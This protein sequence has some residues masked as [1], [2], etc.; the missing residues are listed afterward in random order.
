MSD[1]FTS[2]E[3]LFEKRITEMF[4]SRPPSE[5]DMLLKT[6]TMIIAEQAPSDDMVALYNLLSMEDFVRVI[7]LFD[8]RMIKFFSR[9]EIQEAFVLAL[10]FYYREIEGLDWKDIS[11]KLPIP[12]NPLS[13]GSRVK[14]LSQTVKQQLAKTL[15]DAS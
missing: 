8:G 15:G 13:Y 5:F 2:P 9:K 11:E 6:V 3:N 7:N 12:V 14:K 4:K 10:C 1:M